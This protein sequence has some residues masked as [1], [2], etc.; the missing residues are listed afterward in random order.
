MMKITKKKALQFTAV[1]LAAISLPFIFKY[2]FDWN[3]G[4]QLACFFL[5]YTIAVSGLDILFGYSGQI[6]MG[7]AAFYAIGAYGSVLLHE[8]LHLPVMLTMIL[9]AVLAA[10]IG[11]ALAYPASK[12]VFHFLSLATI[13]FG[14][15]VYQF[16]L[17]SPG[18][19]T[20]NFLGKF[21]ETMSFFGLKLDSY[22]KYY[23]FALAAAVLLL[24]AK[25]NL[26][27]SR[28]GRAMIAIRENSHAAN[29]MG[30][31]VRKYKV[32]AFA[33]SAF[34]TAYAG[35]LYAHLVRYISPDTFAYKQSVM[36]MTMLLFGGTAS[37]TG[38]MMGVLSVQ[39]LNEV[40][41]SAEK[42][43]TLIYGILL[44]VV[45]VAMP[46][47]LSSAFKKGFARKSKKKEDSNHAEN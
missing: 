46:G 19:F 8:Y 11:A 47:G 27:N 28:A 45:I 44:L 20:G 40:L 42:Y 36:F 33:I 16:L 37:C 43:Q 30:I 18:G 23:F 6:S 31:N 4:I 41:R 25:Q 21:T 24:I 26:V 14:E 3:Y 12:L 38:P 17:Q 5:L 7:H 29:G 10:A 32:M 9:A 22:T 35:S 13:A 1:S 2:G 15:V 34:Y 39:A